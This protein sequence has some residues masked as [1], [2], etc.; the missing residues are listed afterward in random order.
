MK[1]GTYTGSNAS[2]HVFRGNGYVISQN[3]TDDN[4]CSGFDILAP[5]T[6]KLF[7]DPPMW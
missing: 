7:S 3:K 6:L 2:G 5:L 4:I 1:S